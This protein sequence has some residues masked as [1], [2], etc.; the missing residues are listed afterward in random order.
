MSPVLAVPRLEL[1]PTPTG[2]M[3]EVGISLLP[4]E[5]PGQNGI[6]RELLRRAQPPYPPPVNY[7]GFINGKAGAVLMNRNRDLAC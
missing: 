1:V 4:T 2:L 3:A 6:P 5:A 7:C